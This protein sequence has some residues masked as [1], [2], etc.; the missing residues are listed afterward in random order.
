MIRVLSAILVLACALPAFAA[1]VRVQGLSSITEDQALELL[2]G[3]LK[4]VKDRPAS[5]SRADDAAFL[6]ERLLNKQ[7]FSN[8]EVEWS[9]PGGNIIQLRVKEGPRSFLGEVWIRGVD[10]TTVKDLMAQF[11]TAHH[12]QRGF[13]LDNYTP[14]LPENNNTGATNAKHHLQSLGYWKASVEVESAK[15]NPRT[16]SVAVILDV[17]TGP[18]HR[19]ATP[20]LQ[21]SSPVDPAL[22]NKLNAFAGELATTESINLARKRVT[23]HYR[24]EGFQFADIRMEATHNNGT[25]QLI[26]LVQPGAQYRVGNITVVGQEDIKP[27]IIEERF[28]GLTGEDYDDSLFDHR[29]RK[30]FATGAFDTLRLKNTVGPNGTLDATLHVEEAKP[31][32]YYIYAGAGSYEGGILGAGYYHRNTFGKL[33]NFSAGLEMSGIGL[34]GEVRI[35]DP[36]FLGKDL[37]FTPRAFILTRAYDGYDKTEG[38]FGLELEWD[39]TDRYSILLHQKNS[40][41]TLSSTGIPSMELGPNDYTVHTIGV[42]QKYDRRNDTTLPTNGYYAEL[43]TELGLAAGDAS[44]SFTRIEGK[45]SIYQPIIEDVSHIAVGVRGGMIIPSVDEEDLPI[46]LRYFNGGASTVRSFAERELGPTASNGDPRGGEA[47]WAANLEY[48][49]KVKGPVKVVAFYD[50]GALNPNHSDF[51]GG[52]IKSALG[53]GLRLHLPIGP[54]RFEYGHALSPDPGDPDGTFHF[55][56]GTA[57]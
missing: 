19:L 11:Q 34:L 39:V 12:A 47:F 16:G 49:H 48:I 10:E 27:G 56:I 7:G 22:R 3:R 55:A 1:K 17:N 30:L 29:I 57:F 40:Y 33:W 13:L 8:P 50:I 54:V 38:G 15:R 2:G 42:T 28:A 5:E 41:S 44:V 31:D 35:T 32:G 20:V 6:L 14:Y 52:E 36:W 37:R 46:D 45:L 21:T 53:L 43:T 9:L 24:R 4:Y 23:K 51:G 25:T 18:L 26:F